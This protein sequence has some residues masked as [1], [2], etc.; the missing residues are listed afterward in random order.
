MKQ[1]DYKGIYP[2]F[3]ACYDDVGNI[4]RTA[5]ALARHCRLPACGPYT[6]MAP[7]ANAYLSVEERMQMLEAVMDAVGGTLPIIARGL[8]QHAGFRAPGRACG[9]AG[10]VGHRRHPAHLF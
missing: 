3:C 2:A 1:I 10:R 8:Q 5:Q 4:S 7:P 9:Q 6:S